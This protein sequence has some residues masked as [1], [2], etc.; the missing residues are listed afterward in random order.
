[1]S[2]SEEYREHIRGEVHR[3]NVENNEMYTEIDEL[4]AELNL[5]QEVDEL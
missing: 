2:L 3:R 5:K 1:M 4:I